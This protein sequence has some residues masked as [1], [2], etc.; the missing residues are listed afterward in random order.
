MSHNP[1]FVHEFLQECA[2]LFSTAAAATRARDQIAEDQ[3]KLAE[4]NGRLRKAL[5]KVKKLK[6]RLHP[7][8]QG[9]LDE[10]LAALSRSAKD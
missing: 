8:Q 7:A 5:E 1:T 6:K 2:D 3:V 10:I 4:E 9:E